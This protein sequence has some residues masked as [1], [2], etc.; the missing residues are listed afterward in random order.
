M[1]V[2]PSVQIS[3]N[4]KIACTKARNGYQ[5]HCGIIADQNTSDPENSLFAVEIQI[6][7]SGD[8]S[9]EA[10]SLENTYKADLRPIKKWH[11]RIFINNT[12]PDKDQHPDKGFFI[13]LPLG[14]SVF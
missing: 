7:N 13:E 9:S 10:D 2:N 14:V 11:R 5:K 6:K 4:G 12:K 1:S 3:F 8:K